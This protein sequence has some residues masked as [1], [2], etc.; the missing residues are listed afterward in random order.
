MVADTLVAIEN[1]YKE[2]TA[3]NSRSIMLSKLAIMEFC[4]WLEEWMDSLIRDLD[5]ATLTDEAWVKEKVIDGTHGFDYS[6]HLRPMMC[7][8]IGEY[9]TRKF[10]ASFEDKH[11]GELELLRQNLSSLW[12]TRCKL[13]HADIATHKASQLK[14]NAP[15]WTNNQFRVMSKRLAVYKT[16]LLAVI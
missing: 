3:D 9:R 14:V 11:P 15:S 6:K 16:E 4:G 5:K 12:V 7:K 10:E 8:I 1:W 13:A 2:P